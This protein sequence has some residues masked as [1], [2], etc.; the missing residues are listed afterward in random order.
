MLG[1]NFDGLYPPNLVPYAI[2]S[3][4]ATHNFTSFH[5]LNSSMRNRLNKAGLK[6]VGGHYEYKRL[7]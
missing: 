2:T 6:I 5:Y 4:T 7:I 1:R 3:N